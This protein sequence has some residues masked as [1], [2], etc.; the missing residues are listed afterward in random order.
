MVKY[1]RLPLVII[2][3]SACGPQARA[4]H[5]S[6]ASADGGF[7]YIKRDTREATRKATLA[8]YMPVLDW[9]PWHIIGPFDFTGWTQHNVIYPPETEIDLGAVYRGKGG[10]EVRWQALD[11]QDWLAVD[12]RRFGSDDANFNSLAYLYREVTSNEAGEITMQMGSDDGLKFWF[13]GKLLVDADAQRG[14]NATDHTVTLPLKQGRNTILAK[15]TNG[16][17]NWEFVMQPVL[18]SRILA[19]LEYQLNIDFPTNPEDRHYRLLTVLEPEEV[20]LEVGGLDVMDDGR[21]IVTTRRGDAWVVEG[22]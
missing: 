20:V 3:L 19:R 4:Q 12:L 8:Q 7:T 15:V 13:N 11:H 22:A 6:G 1:S 21:P 14:L 5:S 16:A 18:D 10:R 2:V 17:A 9:Q